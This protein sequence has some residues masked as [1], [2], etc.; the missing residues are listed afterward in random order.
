MAED[1]HPSHECR[2]LAARTQVR[3]FELSYPRSS[4]FIGGFDFLPARNCS[5]KFEV[6]KNFNR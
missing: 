6:R 5:R 4:A 1:G 2:I 3:M